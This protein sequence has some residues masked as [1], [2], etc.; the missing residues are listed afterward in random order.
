M[1]GG[2]TGSGGP[3]PGP[4]ASPKRAREGREEEENAAARDSQPLTLAALQQALQINQQQ[5]TESIQES[6]AGIGQRVSQVEVN[7]EEHVKRTVA[8]GHDGPP[9]SHR[10][11]CEQGC[12]RT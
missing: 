9:R 11:V 7:M 2:R 10:A 1:E 3:G 8:R 4:Q 5:I 6:I 12:L